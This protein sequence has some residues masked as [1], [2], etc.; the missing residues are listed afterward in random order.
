MATLVHTW[1]FKYQVSFCHTSGVSDPL[2]LQ[3]NPRRR[4]RL[5]DADT[6][7]RMLAAG[8]RLIATQGLSLS[9]E[10]LRMEELITDAGVSR[11]SSY[12]R[13]PTKDLYAADLLLHVAEHTQLTDDLTV[14]LDATSRLAPD[15]VTGITTPQGR[16]DLIVELMRLIT[17]A[18]FTLALASS[19]WRGFVMLRA[20]HGGLPDG[21]LRARVAAALSATER[22]FQSRREAALRAAAGLMGYRLRDASSVDWPDLALLTS[23][24]FTGLLIQAYSDPDAVL[25]ESTRTAF[26]STRAAPWS[27]ATLAQAFLFFGAAEPDPAVAW[28]DERLATTGAALGDLRATLG[29]LWVADEQRQRS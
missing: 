8:E 4:P 26:G 11:T 10:H 6:E 1:Y 2:Q 20:A 27:A 19:T 16:R 15:L 22:G 21:T 23:A 17:A 9:L 7:G 12:R 28:D 13:W 24:S 3:R 29:A 18:D 5:S 14:Y 25:G